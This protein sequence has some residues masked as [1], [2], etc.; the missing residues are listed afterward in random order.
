MLKS[1]A[2]LIHT[3]AE[4]TAYREDRLAGLQALAEV[5]HDFSDVDEWQMQLAQQVQTALKGTNPR[6]YL[7]HAAHVWHQQ[8]SNNLAPDQ[9]LST[10]I[11]GYRSLKHPGRSTDQR[12]YPQPLEVACIGLADFDTLPYQT[13]RKLDEYIRVCLLAAAEHCQNHHKLK[14]EDDYDLLALFLALSIRFLQKTHPS[15]Q[16]N[17]SPEVANWNLALTS[18]ISLA[19]ANF[20]A[21]GYSVCAEVLHL[22]GRPVERESELLLL[23][24]MDLIEY[25]LDEALSDAEALE[26]LVNPQ[27]NQLYAPWLHLY[28]DCWQALAVTTRQR[29][30]NMP[31]YRTQVNLIG[32]F[33]RLIGDQ[34]SYRFVEQF[35]HGPLPTQ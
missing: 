2:P 11:I 27:L 29:T 23:A 8:T 25:L 28:A 1:N 21:G 24:R 31:E 34:D 33:A 35:Q 19:D 9:P 4:L 10:Q 16:L 30:L 32:L 20:S 22:L 26:L 14:D 12:P 5:I 3:D 18:L 13:L 7:R 17:A 15:R 6:N